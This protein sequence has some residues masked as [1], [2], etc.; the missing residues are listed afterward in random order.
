MDYFRERF[1]SFILILMAICIFL[2]GPQNSKLFS[3]IAGFIFGAGIFSLVN[4]EFWS[5][6]KYYRY[7]GNSVED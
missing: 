4:K 5:G 1:V 7:Y 6:F 3:A 2:W